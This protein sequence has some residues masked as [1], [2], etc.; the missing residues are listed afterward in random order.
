[1][2]KSIE[3]ALLFVGHQQQQQQQQQQHCSLYL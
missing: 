3:N 1:V 2:L